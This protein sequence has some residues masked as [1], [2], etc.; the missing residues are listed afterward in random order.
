MSK[1]DNKITLI[2]E[3]GVWVFV[4][5]LILLFGDAIIGF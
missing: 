5:I 3:I 2:F 4:L 1:R